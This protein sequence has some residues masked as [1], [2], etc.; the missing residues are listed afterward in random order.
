MSSVRSPLSQSVEDYLKA[1]YKLQDENS[2]STSEL[3]TRLSVTSASVT[4][5]VK[6][7]SSIGMVTYASYKGVRLTGTGEKIALEIIRH[8]R[9]LETYLREIMGYDWHEMHT[10]AEHLEHHISEEF[11]ERLDVMLGY[12]TH[13]PHGDPIPGRDGS[14]VR[15]HS[16]PIALCPTGVDLTVQRVSD[17]NTHLLRELESLGLLPGAQCVLL[18]SASGTDS[19]L[20]R[21][22]AIEHRLDP[23][24]ASHVFASPTHS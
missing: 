18:E 19:I 14:M 20:V 24:L 15:V 16:E 3:A 9:L 5:M 7:L 2:V 22:A 10:E 12:P 4:N 13:D 23:E 6:R 1:I 17:S 21:S 11:E 8:H